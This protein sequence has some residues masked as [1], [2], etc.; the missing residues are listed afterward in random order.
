M[1]RSASALQHAPTAI[2]GRASPSHQTPHTHADTAPPEAETWTRREERDK[3]GAREDGK[4]E[5]TTVEEESEWGRKKVK[6]IKK[7]RK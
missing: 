2:T 7:I 6:G 3:T 1:V 4:R 5:E